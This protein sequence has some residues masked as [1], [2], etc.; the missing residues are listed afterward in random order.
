MEQQMPINSI[1]ENKWKTA[2]NPC[3]SF[4][5]MKKYVTIEKKRKK[6]NEVQKNDTIF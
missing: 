4:H 3:Y 5:S 1:A 6:E 2:M